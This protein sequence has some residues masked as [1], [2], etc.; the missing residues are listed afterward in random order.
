MRILGPHKAT[1]RELEL[2][3]IE[4]R[5]LENLTV[6]PTAEVA[7]WNRS[8]D[9]ALEGVSGDKP[10]ERYDAIARTEHREF[11]KRVFAFYRSNRCE[12]AV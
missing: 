4:A 6:K 11:V 5:R 2:L 9:S 8:V 12:S 7:A 10:E 3:L 1:R